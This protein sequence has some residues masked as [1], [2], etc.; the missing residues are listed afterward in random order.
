[1][2]VSVSESVCVCALECACVSE[3][4]R[5]LECVCVCVRKY[6]DGEDIELL[7]DHPGDRAVVEVDVGHLRAG[8]FKRVQTRQ[9]SVNARGRA[10]ACERASISARMRKCVQVNTNGQALVCERVRKIWS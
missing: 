8:A 5:A 9:T 3:G 6:L 4:V 2:R 1:M 10:P 7:G